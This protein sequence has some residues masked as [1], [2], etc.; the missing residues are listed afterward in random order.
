LILQQDVHH[1]ETTTRQNHRL[2][3][4][5]SGCG[6]TNQLLYRK[7]HYIPSP[8]PDIWDSTNSLAEVAA[9]PVLLA[10]E[11]MVK[12]LMVLKRRSCG[13]RMQL[14]ARPCWQQTIV[15]IDNISFCLFSFVP[16]RKKCPPV[17]TFS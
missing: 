17:F 7:L 1:L 9:L 6:Y 11:V 12:E 14:K 16:D 8:L 3:S 5:P 10:S 13:C 2:L 15:R 4:R